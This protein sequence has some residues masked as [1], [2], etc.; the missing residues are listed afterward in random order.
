MALMRLRYGSDVLEE[1]EFTPQGFETQVVRNDLGIPT[2]VIKTLTGKI[3]IVASGDTAINAR[4]NQI[5]SIFSMDGRDVSFLMTDGSP[6]FMSLY[7]AGSLY[8]VQ[9]DGPR[10]G[11]LD[12][13]KGDFVSGL[14]TFISFQAEYSPFVLTDPLLGATESIEINGTGG[15]IG[16]VTILDNAQPV[17]DFVS[18]ASPV[19]VVQSGER[20][21]ELSKYAPPQ[22]P[23]FNPPLFPE[24][25]LNPPSDHRQLHEKLKTRQA[26][27][28]Q[29]RA[30]WN[31]VFTFT[32]RPAVPNPAA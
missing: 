13:E 10:W 5:E 7:N 23:P 8:G 27:K 2:S 19:F 20:I 21:F 30:T 16:I 14:T 15:P 9:V 31:Y 6:S 1:G 12:V 18:P 24:N 3:E 26:G 29:Y 17:L 11:P 4:A 22:Y 25:I 32:G 28:A